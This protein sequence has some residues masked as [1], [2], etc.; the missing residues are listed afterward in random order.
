LAGQV[1]HTGERQP[2]HPTDPHRDLDLA[3][4]GVVAVLEHER[5]TTYRDMTWEPKQVFGALAAAYA[6]GL[7]VVPLVGGE[8]V[9]PGDLVPEGGEGPL[10]RGRPVLWDV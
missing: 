1:V 3:C 7:E 9:W 10:A 4:Y 6:R 2:R 5:G 8:A